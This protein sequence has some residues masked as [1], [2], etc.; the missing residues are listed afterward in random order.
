[1]RGGRREGEGVGG[2][3]GEVLLSS[4]GLSWPELSLLRSARSLAFVCRL[5][6][7]LLAFLVPPST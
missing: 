2:G 1:M 4:D 6:L 3:V 7:L 5:P